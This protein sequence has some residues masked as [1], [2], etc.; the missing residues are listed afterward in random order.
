MVIFLVKKY[1]PGD[2]LFIQIL[3]IIIVIPE[4][5]LRKQNGI[6]GRSH[7]Y[8]FCTAVMDVCEAICAS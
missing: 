6:D 3:W 5:V 2:C 1:F 7:Y 8:L 4:I